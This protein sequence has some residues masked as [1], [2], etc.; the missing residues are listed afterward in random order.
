MG[1]RGA[2]GRGLL[3][4]KTQSCFLRSQA[5]GLSFQLPSAPSAPGRK[6]NREQEVHFSGIVLSRIRNFKVGHLWFL[7]KSLASLSVDPYFSEGLQGAPV[8]CAVSSLCSSRHAPCRPRRYARPD[9]DTTST[10]ISA[11]R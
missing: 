11:S 9:P 8:T 1:S 3:G 2:W 4:P 7:A 5:A 10:C 6:G